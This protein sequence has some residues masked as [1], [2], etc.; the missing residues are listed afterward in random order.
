MELE[1]I[2]QPALHKTIA[3]SVISPEDYRKFL[4]LE[5]YN[6]QTLGGKIVPS[7]VYIE[8]SY[9]DLLIQLRWFNWG[10][11]H[12]CPHKPD[13][14]SQIGSWMLDYAEVLRGYSPGKFEGAAWFASFGKRDSKQ[15]RCGHI[16]VSENISGVFEAIGHFL[17]DVAEMESK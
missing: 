7:Y 17:L 13:E 14:I 16:S 10:N 8:H 2:S 4:E 1:I 15:E 9:G 11:Y 6:H 12:R 3:I 5:D